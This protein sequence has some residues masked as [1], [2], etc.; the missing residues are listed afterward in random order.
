VVFIVDGSKVIS[1]WC[2][3]FDG[4]SGLVVTLA[5]SV[6]VVIRKIAKPPTV[7]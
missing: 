7:G 1:A 2:D 3:V 6:F 5:I 4:T